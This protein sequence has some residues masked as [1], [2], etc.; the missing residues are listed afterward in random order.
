MKEMRRQ[1]L[2]LLLLHDIGNGWSEG[3]GALIIFISPTKQPSDD[4]GLEQ[5]AENDEIKCV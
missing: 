1:R 4:D 3:R 5:R 2:S